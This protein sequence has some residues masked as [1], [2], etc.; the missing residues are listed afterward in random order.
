[1]FKDKEKNHSSAKVVDGNLIISLPDAKD[2]VVWRMALGEARAAAL[3]VQTR[4]NDNYV[5]VLKYPKGDAIDIAPFLQ[6]QTATEALMAVSRAMQ[7]AQGHI[8][9]GTRRADTV[10]EN[11][12]A[13]GKWKW[14][15]PLA[16]I[17]LAL[18]VFSRTATLVPAEVSDSTQD[19]A[20][21]TAS[22][23]GSGASGVPQSADSLLNGM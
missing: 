16:L 8:L 10:M 22:S 12:Q 6:K 21:T 4:A 17:V 7:N 5:L 20:S 19:N 1:M 2:P 9:N 13:P 23:P 15:L 3:E 14:L 11:K 18:F